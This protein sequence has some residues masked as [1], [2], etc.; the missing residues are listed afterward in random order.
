MTEPPATGLPPTIRACLFDLDG[1]LTPTAAIHAKA[2]TEMFDGFLKG[3]AADHGEPYV[4]FDPTADYDTYVDGRIRDDGTRAFLASRHITL[5]EGRPNDAPTRETI[6]GLGNAKNGIFLREVGKGHLQAYEG[7]VRYL[8]AV[9]AAG[10]RCAVVSASANCPDILA[11]TGIS[12]LLDVRVD[13][14]TAARDHLAGKPAPDTYLAAARDL[15]VDPS[16]AA[17]FEDAL[18]GVEAGRAGEFGYVVG[19]DRVGQA[20]ELRTH[21]ADTVV[22]DLADLLDRS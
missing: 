21:G 18:S 17:V 3:Y 13:G 15:G 19:V 20:D 4:A 10:L 22:K 2:W 12:D 1:V 14:L 8:H 11:A 7:S 6:S 9:R 5:P 16:Q